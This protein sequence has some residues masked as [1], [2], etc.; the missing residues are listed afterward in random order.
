MTTPLN[1]IVE[2]QK[3]FFKEVQNKFK[4]GM[5]KVFEEVPELHAISWQQYTPSFNDGEPC[6]NCLGEVYFHVDESLIPLEEQ[7]GEDDTEDGGVS[8]WDIKNR[9]GI[10][11]E[12]KTF[13][14]TFSKEFHELDTLLERI[15][16]TNQ[17]IRIDRNGKITVEEYDCG[18]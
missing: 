1:E 6:E 10:S 3:E 18:Y 16:G 15:F 2:Q 12:F 4:E 7:T 8:A 14:S 11:Q 13:I 17:Q 5:K 9:E